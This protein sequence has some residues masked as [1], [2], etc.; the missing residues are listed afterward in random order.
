MGEA[1]C[2]WEKLKV[3]GSRWEEARE[4]EGLSTGKSNARSDFIGDIHTFL[5]PTHA[6]RIVPMNFSMVLTSV[7][8]LIKTGSIFLQKTN[9]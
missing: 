1:G 2:R 6:S 5:F 3:S 7:Q 4:R 8:N 9:K